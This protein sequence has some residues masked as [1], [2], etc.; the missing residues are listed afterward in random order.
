MSSLRLFV[1]EISLLR[2]LLG[3]C[4]P[5]GGFKLL[6]IAS[7]PESATSKLHE[8]LKKDPPKSDYVVKGWDT[9]LT[10]EEGTVLDEH[11]NRN[12]WIALF[13]EPATKLELIETPAKVP[14]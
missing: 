4:G 7:S 11:L 9:G 8:R 3:T 13:E 2:S 5:F 14:A 10:L 6:I 1:F 12:K